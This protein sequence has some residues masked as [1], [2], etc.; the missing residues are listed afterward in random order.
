MH[1]P[2][3]PWCVGVDDKDWPD[4]GHDDEE[5]DEDEDDDQ[6]KDEGDEG[7]GG[8]DD[9]AWAT[10]RRSCMKPSNTSGLQRFSHSDHTI[11]STNYC[12][13]PKTIWEHL[14]Q[15]VKD[16][17]AKKHLVPRVCKGLARCEGQSACQFVYRE[18]LASDT[19]SL[20]QLCFF[21]PNVFN[22]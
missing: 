9:K 21:S 18:I 8:C 10:M 17:N 1:N 12:N 16:E 6:G 3:S 2:F 14:P 20:A 13:I 4:Q 19:W 22:L 7:E 11:V 5:G 15:K